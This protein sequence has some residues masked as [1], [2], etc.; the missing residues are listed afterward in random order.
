MIVFK[1]ELLVL[2]SYLKDL[3]N[4][5]LISSKSYLKYL[6]QKRG[7]AQFFFFNQKNHITEMMMHFLFGGHFYGLRAFPWDLN[8]YPYLLLEI[9]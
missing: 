8:F 2:K 5:N 9:L 1:G 3:F 6:G 7:L 4:L